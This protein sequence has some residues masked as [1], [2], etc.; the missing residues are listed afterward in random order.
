MGVFVFVYI[1]YHFLIKLFSVYVWRMLSWFSVAKNAEMSL[2]FLLFVGAILF[3]WIL[4]PID[5]TLY[6]L[7]VFDCISRAC[8]SKSMCGERTVS[9]RLMYCIDELLNWQY[10]HRDHKQATK[11][12]ITTRICIYFKTSTWKS[13]VN[14]WR[15]VSTL[16]KTGRIEAKTLQATKNICVDCLAM[17]RLVN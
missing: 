7:G 9:E 16:V 8:W 1:F 5:V 2:L 6:S 15:A 12:N 3:L 13:L 17:V 10:E 4:S 14:P 11:R